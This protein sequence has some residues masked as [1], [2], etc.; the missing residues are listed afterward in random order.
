MAGAEKGVDTGARVP[1]AAAPGARRGSATGAKDGGRASAGPGE[2]R[3]AAFARGPVVGAAGALLVVLAATANLYGFH[4]DELYFRMLPPAWGY[5]DQ[6]P[7]TPALVRLLAGGVDEPWAIRIPAIAFA[8]ASV[9]VVALIA[10]EVGGSHL[11]Q[12]LAAWGYAFGSFTLSFGHVMLPASADLLVWPAV[13]LLVIRTVMRRQGQWML[14]AGVIVGLSTYNKL[15][16]VMLLA[17]IALAL[18]ALGPRWIFR[19]P[20]LYAG[21]GAIVVIGFPNLLY[22]LQNGL[23]QLTM[24]QALSVHNGASVRVMMWPF[25]ALMLGP[26]LV[27]FWVAALVSLLRRPQ[28]RSLRFLVLAFALVL[29]FMFI[30]ATQ[31]YYSYGLLASLFA[32]GCVP[33]AEFAARS[34]ARRRLVYTAVVLNSVVSVVI[35]LPVIPAAV[36]GATP[37]PAIDQV[38]AD[39]LGWPQYVAE[40]EAVARSAAGATADGSAASGSTIVLASNYGEAGALERYGSA[41]LPPLYSAHNAL[42]RS[43]PPPADTSTVIVVG[44]QVRTLGNF[45]ASCETVAHLDNGEGVDNE[46][47]G[48]PISICRGP[49][50]PWSTLWP[51]LAHLD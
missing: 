7:L 45:F 2:R 48:D 27:P 1:A 10:R 47:Q 11:A 50:E 38:A 49:V 34:T 13:V 15:L 26:L 31:S 33:V 41:D 43:G 22:Q 4:R 36:V 42:I 23:P 12:G 9:F 20:W 19:S 25:L 16:V 32:I 37:I 28:W 40:V 18:A 46:E 17:A 14:V 21:L 24:G 51:K 44:S 35:S 5:I 30:G 29:L 6:P 3:L 39:Q 8:V